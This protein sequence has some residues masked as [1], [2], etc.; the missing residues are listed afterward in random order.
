[1]AEQITYKSA[2]GNWITGFVEEKRSLGFKYENEAKWMRHFDR[3]WIE[4]QY[5]REGLTLDNLS[6]WIQRR[7]SEGVKC[8]A[9][10]ISVIRQYAFYLNGI[11]IASYCPPLNVRYA[12]PVIHLLEDEEIRELFFY[13]DSYRP[14]KG[15]KAVFRMAEEYPVLFRLIYVNGLRIS[16]ALNLRYEDVDLN[17]G[18]AVILNGKG[19]RD[20]IVYMHEDMTTLL[21]NYSMFLKDTLG[22]TS[23]WL[24]PGYNPDFHVSLGCVDT[25]F[26][27]CWKKT[28]FAAGC[29]RNPTVHGL[30]HAYVVRR[31]D[32]WRSQ[33]L[34]FEH[35]LPYISKYLGHKSFEETYYYYHYMKESAR[36]I[37]EKDTVI[38]RVIP[39]VMRR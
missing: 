1:M 30:R 10:R 15:G 24:F 21:C 4:H 35:I 39:E 27:K 16:E 37:R 26:R 9:T 2:V 23:E 3:Y 29:D 18:T 20:R 36:T 5:G 7:E 17:E 14:Q 11:G 33:G 38:E 19:N 8:L 28:S 25:V 6:D 31:I 22:R 32:L 34:D 12:K 13:I